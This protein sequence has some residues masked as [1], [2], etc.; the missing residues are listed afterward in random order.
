MT[1]ILLVWYL[2]T[3]LVLFPSI[4]LTIDYREI[5]VRRKH[6]I[7]NI[8]EFHDPCFNI[9]KPLIEPAQFAKITFTLRGTT[10]DV[11][12]KCPSCLLGE[13]SIY[14]E[15]IGSRGQ[16]ICIL[17]ESLIDCL[18]VI[19]DVGNVFRVNANGDYTVHKVEES[20]GQGN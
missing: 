8:Q 12:I 15:D 9:G 18:H 11:L 2:D 1:L 14:P 4:S 19:D 5:Y 6:F 16:S 10:E 20:S 17:K 7:G 3:P 13:I